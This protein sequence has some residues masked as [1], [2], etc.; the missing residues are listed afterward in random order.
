MM[1][2]QMPPTQ[3]RS[4]FQL[5]NNSLLG[6]R[7]RTWHTLVH[8]Q[9]SQQEHIRVAVLRNERPQLAHTAVLVKDCHSVSFYFATSASRFTDLLI[10][11]LPHLRYQALHSNSD[12]GRLDDVWG[13]LTRIT[14]NNWFAMLIQMNID[15]KKLSSRLSLF[16]ASALRFFEPSIQILATFFSANF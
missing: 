7:I 1:L 6:V 8:A 2:P 4:I 16:Q 10:N 3:A 13:Q 11:L 12:I 14:R 15:S 9:H 5:F